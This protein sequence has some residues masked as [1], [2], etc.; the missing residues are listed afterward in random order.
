MPYFRKRT[1]IV[2]EAF[3]CLISSRRAIATTKSIINPHYS[4]QYQDVVKAA[5]RI[6]RV[7]AHVTPVLTSMSLN[8]MIS[9]RQDRELR[10]FF[11]AECLQR[12]GSFKFRGAANAILSLLE[13]ETKNTDSSSSSSNIHIVSHSSGNH[14]QGLA[15]VANS[16]QP[17]NKLETTIFMPRGASE[18]KK[19]SV[20]GYGANVV[21]T[22]DD[23]NS[24][25]NEARLFA[26]EINTNT[27]KKAALI[28][29]FEDVHVMAGQGT[30]AFELVQQVPDL[31]VV[32]IPV[33]GGAL[34]SGCS[35]VLRH[36]LGSNVTILL[37]EPEGFDDT[38]RS[39]IGN[40]LVGH[41]TGSTN[42][43]NNNQ[44]SSTVADGLKAELGALQFPIL[45]DLVD[46]VMV[47]TDAEI[48]NATRL[49]WERLNVIVE[50]SA[51]IGLAILLGQ[52]F[53]QLLLLLST[54]KD[55]KN[56]GVI[57][58]GGNCDIGTVAQQF[59]QLK[60]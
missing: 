55:I 60:D 41:S 33:G 3:S 4:I 58:C 29:P 31:D 8:Q 56:V 49:L 25:I 22:A 14:A 10:V 21:L 46:D 16:L 48:L 6:G 32:I 40:K 34:A 26:H 38:R 9:S 27:N 18:A 44:T 59:M 53:Q 35:V 7:G 17:N 51:A 19:Q 50:P 23:T 28:H 37:A 12:T 54:K 45:R 47:A 30:V 1:T 2:T 42:N 20:L 57:L 36:V 5:E 43:N 24:R 52:E 13:E 15:C 39:L 11:K